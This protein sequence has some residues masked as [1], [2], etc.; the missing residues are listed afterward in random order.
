MIYLLISLILIILFISIY[1]NSR[2]FIYIKSLESKVQDL[3]NKNDNMYQSLNELVD[4]EYLLSD[5]RL[6]KF[7][8]QKDTNKIYNGIKIDEQQVEF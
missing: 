4:H 1:I 3:I 8:L 2:L 5:G 7:I 6:K